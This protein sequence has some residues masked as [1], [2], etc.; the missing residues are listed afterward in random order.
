MSMTTAFYQ[1]VVADLVALRGY[2]KGYAARA[3][4][5]RQVLK[6]VEEAAEA[7]GVLGSVLPEPLARA[8][9]AVGEDARAHFDAGWPGSMLIADVDRG[10]RGYSDGKVRRLDGS[11][12]EA[13][14]GMRP[15]L[16]ED[17]VEKGKRLGGSFRCQ[18]LDDEEVNDGVA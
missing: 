7:A 9:A 4:A 12:E 13:R 17:W 11:T 6:A 15:E 14:G 18:M 10:V 3:Y 2:R 8:L 5:A 16:G 1:E